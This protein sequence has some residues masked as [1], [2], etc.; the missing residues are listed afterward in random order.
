MLIDLNDQLRKAVIEG[1][2]SKLIKWIIRQIT[3][4]KH[5][6]SF[7]PVASHIYGERH[8]LTGQ[9]LAKSWEKEGDKSA[10][11]LIHEG[12]QEKAF[13]ID[14]AKRTSFLR[15]EYP[16]KVIDPSNL[17]QISTIMTRSLLIWLGNTRKSI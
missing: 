15:R 2:K 9:F 17:S 12:I 8:G 13:K 10:K 5:E 3:R 14:N 16:N 6:G 1:S 4:L 7:K 11:A